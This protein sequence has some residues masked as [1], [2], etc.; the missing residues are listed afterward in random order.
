MLKDSKVGFYV[1]RLCVVA[2]AYADDI[3]LLALSVRAMRVLLNVCDELAFKYDVVF[4]ACKSKCLIF[5][6][7]GGR[8]LHIVIIYQRLI[9]VLEIKR[10]SSWIAGH[11]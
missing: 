8:Q 1:G 6:P 2:V 4:N 9:F 10:L 3:V 7:S 11:T 5:N